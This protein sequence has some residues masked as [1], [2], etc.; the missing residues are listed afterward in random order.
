[1]FG[2]F[3]KLKEVLSGWSI[4][5]KWC[6]CERFGCGVGLSAVENGVRREIRFK[7]RVNFVVL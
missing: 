1:M 7:I 5:S 6:V 2:V 3:W 4:E